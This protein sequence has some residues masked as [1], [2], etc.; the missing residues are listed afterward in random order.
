MYQIY[1]LLSL[2]AMTWAAAI[3]ASFDEPTGSNR[4]GPYQAGDPQ[5]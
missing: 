4:P 1:A 3:W 5:A 2:M